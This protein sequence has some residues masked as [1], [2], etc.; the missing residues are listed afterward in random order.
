MLASE[1]LKAITEL[2]YLDFPALFSYFP[3]CLDRSKNSW[4]IPK[5]SQ[6]KANRAEEVIGFALECVCDAVETL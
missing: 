5:Y 1:I 3:G 2:I 6:F 4:K